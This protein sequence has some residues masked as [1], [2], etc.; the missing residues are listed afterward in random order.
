MPPKTGV[1]SFGTGHQDEGVVVSP[2]DAEQA[3]NPLESMAYDIHQIEQKYVLPPVNFPVQV[4]LTT[5]STLKIDCSQYTTNALL[6]T[7]NTGVIFVWLGDFT[8]AN[9][10][11][12]SFSHMVFSA[13]IVP[14]TQVIPLPPSQYIFT[15]QANG[16]AATGYI[17]P[18]AL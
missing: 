1:I 18:L 3:Q 8:N 2:Q 7:V 11:A 16:G 6:V 15:V 5:N 4:N 13:G 12:Q 17:T 9:G 10:V 14:V